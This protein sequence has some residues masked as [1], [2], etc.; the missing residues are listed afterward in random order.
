[1]RTRLKN[2]TKIKGKKELAGGGNKWKGKKEERKK[3]TK[4]KREKKT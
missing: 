3:K 2:D 1:M 4:T